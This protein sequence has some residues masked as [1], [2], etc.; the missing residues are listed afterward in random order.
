MT[1]VDDFWA[2][3]RDASN[4]LEHERNLRGMTT[5]KCQ[6]CDDGIVEPGRTDYDGHGSFY[7]EPVRCQRCTNGR[8]EVPCAADVQAAAISKEINGWRRMLRAVQKRCK[9]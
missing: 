4:R 1:S 9:P 5:A 8:V 3:V 2:C 6:R 7:V